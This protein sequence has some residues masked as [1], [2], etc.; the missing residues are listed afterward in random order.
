M[1]LLLLIFN[2]LFLNLS[3]AQPDESQKNIAFTSAKGNIFNLNWED[4][5]QI[6]SPDLEQMRKFFIS[7]FL[8][9]YRLSHTRDDQS[10]ANLEFFLADYFDH[11]IQPKVKND[12][13]LF[14][15]SA[16]LEDKWVGF[17]LFERVDAET[18]Y[19]G[20]LAISEDFWRQGLGRRM[21]YSI[22]EKDP[23]VHKI[24]LLTEWKNLQAQ[25]FYESIG[26]KPV[27]YT[28]T[29]YS[30]DDYRAYELVLLISPAESQE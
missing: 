23:A 18:I 19:M 10:D 1:A 27:D 26:F 7:T 16:K 9:S 14:F 25:K 24:V 6:S 20:E 12:K 13:E 15:L 8:K 4:P 22:I 30:P 3:Y 21:T 5:T 29:G 28:H 11:S 17:A 2:L